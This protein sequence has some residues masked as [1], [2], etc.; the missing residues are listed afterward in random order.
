MEQQ[1]PH[2]LSKVHIRKCRPTRRRSGP[3]PLLLVTWPLN[4]SSPVWS[5]HGAIHRNKAQMGRRPTQTQPLSVCL[6]GWQYPPSLKAHK[7]HNSAARFRAHSTSPHPQVELFEYIIVAFLRY[8]GDVTAFRWFHCAVTHFFFLFFFLHRPTPVFI[9]TVQGSLQ[10]SEAKS[11]ASGCR[12]QLHHPEHIY[13]VF[14]C[15]PCLDSQSTS[16]VC[17]WRID[18]PLLRCILMKEIDGVFVSVGT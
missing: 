13:G 5:K 12:Q 3:L 7:D 15:P 17:R 9:H 6:P 11:W 16:H 10:V 18:H 4:T 14:S 8:S 2:T 1:S